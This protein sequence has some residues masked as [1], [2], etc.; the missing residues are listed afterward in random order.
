MNAPGH[1]GLNT[2][3]SIPISYYLVNNYGLNIGAL[4]LITSV[5]VC[6][7]PDIDIRLQSMDTQII[8]NVSHRGRTHTLQFAIVMC[9]LVFPMVYYLS[10]N[11][12]ISTVVSIGVF[13]GILCHLLGDVLTPSGVN[14]LPLIDYNF[15]L[16]CFRYD[17]LIA[18]TV[19][20]II[21][22]LGCILIYLSLDKPSTYVW[23]SIIIVEIVGFLAVILS[24]RYSV[25]YNES[26]LKY[27]K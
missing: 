14:M 18:N 20:P 26:I 9:I 16:N 4:F 8:G 2:I 7:L 3:L 22:F 25:E 12:Y 23:A 1:I 11:S 10:G 19:L 6:S 21:G 15:C 24:S 13:T 5:L 27:Y 17:N